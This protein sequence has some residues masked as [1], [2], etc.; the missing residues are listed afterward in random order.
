[1][2]KSVTK[3]KN[4]SEHIDELIEFY[5]SINIDDI[6][7]LKKLFIRNLND[8]KKRYEK[9]DIPMQNDYEIVRNNWNNLKEYLEV[10]WK[11]TQDV[12]FVKLLNKMQELE[13]G[14]ISNEK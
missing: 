12:W 14:V 7:R 9:Y 13:V 8:V 2:K 6:E 3:V 10:N 1:M 4:V 5:S 11:T